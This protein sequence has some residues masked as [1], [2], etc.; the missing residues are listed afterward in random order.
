MRIVFRVIAM[1]MGGLLLA[2]VLVLMLVN[3]ALA[4]IPLRTTPVTKE[5]VAACRRALT[6][7]PESAPQS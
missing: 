1:I 3:Q 7:T 4:A 5:D 6:N 2:G